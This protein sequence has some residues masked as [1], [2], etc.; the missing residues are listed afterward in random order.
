MSHRPTGP[1][2]GA[3]GEPRLIDGTSPFAAR[4]SSALRPFARIEPREVIT[5]LALMLTVFLLL[6]AHYVLKTARE[7]LVLLHGGGA[8]T[9]SY[10]AA[11]QS[12]LLLA[13]VPLYSAFARRVNRMRLIA[14]IYG[15]FALNLVLF[16]LLAEGGVALGVAFYVWVGVFNVTAIAVF[17]SF[18]SDVYKPEQGKRLFAILGVGSS[19]GAV[20][21][22]LSARKLALLGPRAMMLS[23]AVILLVCVALFALVHRRERAHMPRARK[24]RERRVIEG[25]VLAGL[26]R[27]RFVLLIALLV[28]LLNCVNA[29]GEYVLDR[30]LL[31]SLP[32][33]VNGDQGAFVAEFKA[34]YFGWV[35][36][37][38]LLLQLFVVSRL[39]KRA[40]VRRSLFI[41][42][43]VAFASYG[44]MLGSPLLVLVLIG[45]IAENSLDYSLDNTARQALFLVGTR[46]EKYVGKTI[47]DTMVVRLGDVSS[48]AMVALG[49][50][51]ALPVAA[52]AAVNL[53][54][55][56]CWLLVLVA[57]G[58]EHR[59]RSAK[60]QAAAARSQPITGTV[61]A[62]PA[63]TAP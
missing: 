8:E 23:A 41:L 25:P 61:A 26:L 45:K 20:V 58:R 17:W 39:L 46:L 34:E 59:R 60:A 15:F 9:K 62:R 5:A 63:R 16:A 1:G 32:E 31:A 29:N 54:L 50:V 6:I 57:L 3:E 22:A 35:N 48:A 24:R 21:G 2:R 30:M 40:G 36:G 10:A 27:D 49:S 7:P 43:L 56:A 18:A 52:F 37:V 51:L 12:L 19:V 11:G 38:S 47:V 4:L 44:V 42:P 53:G 13:G 55:I 33:R 28:L 14:G